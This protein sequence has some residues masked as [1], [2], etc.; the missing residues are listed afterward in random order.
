MMTFKEFVKEMERRVS[1]AMGDGYDVTARK[2]PKNNGVILTGLVIIGKEAG[3]APAVYLD[4]LYRDYRAGKEE[5]DLETMVECITE[6][7]WE[8]RW[9]AK[10]IPID[11]SELSDYRKIKDKILFKLINT[12]ENEALLKQIPNIPFQDMSIVFFLYLE[13]NDGGISTALLHNQHMG[14]WNVTTEDLYHVA[15]ENTPRL[16]PENL[17][18]IDEVIRDLVEETEEENCQDLPRNL[19]GME[20]PLFYILTNRIGIAGA[21][22]L[23]YPGV[24]RKCSEKLGGDLLI[25]PSSIHETLIIVHDE[26]IKTEEMRELVQ[27]VNMTEVPK[28]D[29][30]SSNIYIYSKDRGDIIMA[31]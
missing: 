30:L 17:K 27:F 31:A 9:K 26:T 19:P 28:E 6:V 4:S 5:I 21:A 22:C 16:L 14:L 1:A 24:L 15:K 12:K 25:L 8:G 29:Y 13:E 7:Y 20:A 11:F 23:L 2:V 3:V 10:Q 18:G